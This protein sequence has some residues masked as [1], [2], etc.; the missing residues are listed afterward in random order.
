M[1][2]IAGRMRST[3]VGE[4]RTGEECLDRAAHGVAMLAEN[5]GGIKG[6]MTWRRAGPE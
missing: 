1:D 6:D 4:H 2:T 3:A 5:G